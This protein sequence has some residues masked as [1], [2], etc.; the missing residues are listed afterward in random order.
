MVEDPVTEIRRVY[1]STAMQ[2]PAQEAFVRRFP[3][4]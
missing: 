1:R 4:G 3:T 2:E